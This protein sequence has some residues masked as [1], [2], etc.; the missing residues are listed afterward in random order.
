LFEQ[1][2]TLN[3]DFLDTL[4]ENLT[5]YFRELKCKQICEFD[6]ID[7]ETWGYFVWSKEITSYS[8]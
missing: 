1:R 8:K 2:R 6:E 4:C 5:G 7:K 3:P